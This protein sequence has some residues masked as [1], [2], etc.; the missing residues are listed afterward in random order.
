MFL[1]R[2]KP[3]PFFRATFSPGSRILSNEG[4]T[5]SPLHQDSNGDHVSHG[6]VVLSWGFHATLV[7]DSD[8]PDYRKHG[9]SRFQLVAKELL[10]PAEGS[11][12]HAYH[13]KVSILRPGQPKWEVLREGKDE[14]AYILA[15]MVSNLEATFRISPKSRPLDG[16][17]WIVHFGSMSGDEIMAV[18]TQAYDGGKHVTDERVGYE[19][20]DGVRI[21]FAEE[22]E[23]WRRVCV[24]GQ[25]V[26]V[27]E[28]GWVEV[29]K[30]T[31]GALELVSCY[32][33]DK[34]P[35]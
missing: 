21:E 4:Q 34:T 25:I 22:D 23:R 11:A 9:A 14:H 18:M 6:A 15:T 24:D 10:Y 27:E 7:A 35:G 5:E 19:E 32:E 17:L 2:P 29:K 12:P 16:K 33:E 30:G 13:G 20:I 8:T 28:G 3:L 31:P 26:R 1:G